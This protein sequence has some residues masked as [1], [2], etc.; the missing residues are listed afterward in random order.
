MDLVVLILSATTA[1]ILVLCVCFLLAFCVK[2]GGLSRTAF[3]GLTKLSKNVAEPVVGVTVPSDKD[4]SGALLE[5]T[6]TPRFLRFLCEAAWAAE[7]VYDTRMARSWRSVRN[8]GSALYRTNRGWNSVIH[9]S[10][11][12]DVDPRYDMYT[13]TRPTTNRNRKPGD[14][15][16]E[17]VSVVVVVRGTNSEADTFVDLDATPQPLAGAH[18][19]SNAN[20]HAGIPHAN[21]SLWTD[22][23]YPSPGAEVP[24]EIDSLSVH[25]GFHNRTFLV[26]RRVLLEL[27]GME[28]TP[29]TTFTCIGH[30]LGGAV[31]SLLS[32]VLAWR[33]RNKGNWSLPVGGGTVPPSTPP[34]FRSVTF[35]APRFL[36]SQT[37]PGET[38]TDAASR[39]TRQINRLLE[40][41]WMSDRRTY[42]VVNQGDP[43]PDQPP[44][45]ALGILASHDT[46]Y[47]IV[48]VERGDT[49]KAICDD[50]DDGETTIE[51]VETPAFE[52]DMDPNHR[53]IDT[54]VRILNN[55][56]DANR[57]KMETY[58]KRLITLT[59]DS[60][61]TPTNDM[62][63][64]VT[65]GNVDRVD[66]GPKQLNHPSSHLRVDTQR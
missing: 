13:K 5:T 28:V 41:D 59:Q 23:P 7:L 35:G 22:K 27:D 24:P 47:D 34:R 39:F 9:W 55:V 57:H 56:S 46:K 10:K 3:R 64:I 38:D 16:L 1:G 37:G 32:I 14:P 61:Y 40:A 26:L 45:R 11:D 21:S 48:C 50:T 36:M 66:N 4:E 19:L 17:I 54:V 8:I 53:M 65:F 52:K 60:N 44:R 20:G 33:Y 62:D 25:E 18:A 2:F 30:S 43:V 63:D 51:I 15:D 29:A 12:N 49:E 31:A 42:R 58:A 6:G